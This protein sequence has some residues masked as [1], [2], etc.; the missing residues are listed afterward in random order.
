MRQQSFVFFMEAG[1]F[2]VASLYRHGEVIDL[3]ANWLV[4]FDT[5]TR[6]NDIPRRFHDLNPN[7]IAYYGTLFPVLPAPYNVNQNTRNGLYGPIRT[8]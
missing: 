1:D 4:D 8:P 2:Y 6:Q 3:D 5:F 7:Q